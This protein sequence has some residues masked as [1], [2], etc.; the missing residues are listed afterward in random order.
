[1]IRLGIPELKGQRKQ[2]NYIVLSYCI[3]KQNFD[4][5]RKQNYF[6]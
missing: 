2:E 6:V 1:M 3:F 4:K 5:I